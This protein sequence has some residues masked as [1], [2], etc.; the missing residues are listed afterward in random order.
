MQ[1]SDLR[2]F[3]MHIWARY[4]GDGFS[5]PENASLNKNASFLI[6][7]DTPFLEQFAMMALEIG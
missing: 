1:F 4:E 3:H 5:F 2:H 7:I 6:R